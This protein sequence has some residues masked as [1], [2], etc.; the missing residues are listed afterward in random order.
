M[1]D[2]LLPVADALTR[3]LA[4]M[5]PMPA[6]TVA[7]TAALGRVTAEPI[8]ARRTQPPV[9]VSAMDGYAVRSEDVARVPATLKR[10]GAA[11]AG[12]AFGRT[13]GPGDC[14]RIFTGGPVPA[15]ADAIVIQE[16][17]D[18]D[19]EEDGATV[20]VREGAAAGTYIRPAGLDF[21]EGDLGIV[22]GRRLSA[23][24]IGLAATMNVPW[25][26]VRRRPRV[27]ILSTGDEIVRPGEL[28]DPT[29]IVS[30]NAYALA[31][32]VRAVGGEPI[33]LGIAPDDEGA[34]RRIAAGAR[35]ADMLVTTGGA[36]VGRHDLVQKALGDGEFGADALEV[37]FWKIAMRPGKPLIFGRFA[38][39]PMLGLPGNPVS[40]MVCAT[41]FLRPA[42]ETMLGLTA[43]GAQEEPATLAV[44]LKE[45]DRRQD[46]VRATWERDDGGRRIVRPFSRQDSSM[47]SRLAAADCLIVRPAHD[48]SRKA[49]DSVQVLC[50]NGDFL[51]I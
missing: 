13:V 33:D 11:P 35:G 34:L 42:I 37:G 22:A 18:A 16:D 40:T 29:R 45:N 1:S 19:S 15:G 27:A 12:G 10:I 46:Y 30:S 38:G 26:S 21:H 39:V 51:S 3:I 23:R 20:I 49:G 9:D 17:V 48:P 44:D 25:I 50:L 5:T 28:T 8:T 43:V 31:A 4:A 32:V 24:D 47:M 36:S 6:E 14:V 7:L 2:D 41:V